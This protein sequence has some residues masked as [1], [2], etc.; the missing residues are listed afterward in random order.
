MAE[1]LEAPW[2]LDAFF[3]SS[4][5]Q[6]AR[7]ELVNGQPQKLSEDAANLHDDIVINIVT[8]LA[9]QLHGSGRRAFT[10]AGAVE[11]YPGQIRRPDA[12]VAAGPRDPNAYK[13]RS[14]CVAIE[15]L[16]PFARDFE[17]FEKLPEY[18]TVASLAHILF[19][20]PNAPVVFAWWRDAAGC[21]NEARVEDLDASVTLAGVGATL[22]MREIYDGVEFPREMRLVGAERPA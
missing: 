21:W 10:G 16:S 18:K 11:T 20:E 14:P 7:Y 13:A 8:S 6:T 15:V 12:G 19:V 22:A 4:E 5:K 17:A 9:R 3:A 2:T 1:P